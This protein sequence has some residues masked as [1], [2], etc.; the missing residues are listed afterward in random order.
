M[1]GGLF[2]K[3]PPEIPKR[4]GELLIEEGLITEA[5]LTKALEHQKKHGG[6][7]VDILIG[8]GSIDA[9]TFVK[10][11]SKRPGIPSIDLRNYEVPREL[12]ALIPKEL[13][14]KHEI[15]PIDKMGKVLT[16]G[17]AFPLDR[18]TI[19][20]LQSVTGFKIRPILC[21]GDDIRSAIKQYYGREERA[22]LAR[23][24]KIEVVE[25][26]AESA[27]RIGNI[28]SL[29]KEITV[30]P[31]LPRTV[32]QLRRIIDDPKSSISDVAH[33]LSLDPPASAKLLSITNSAAFSFSRQVRNVQ[34]AVALLGLRQTYETVLSAAAL[35]FFKRAPFFDHNLYWQDAMECANI[36]TIISRSAGLQTLDGV[37][38][39]GIM[40]DIGRMALAWIAPERF[41]KVDQTEGA[42]KMVESEREIFLVAHPEVG[43]MLTSNWGLP[44]QMT[45][46]IRFHHSYEMA[47][48][49]VETAAVI[50]LACG[51]LD[52][53]DLHVDIDEAF[54]QKHLD[55]LDCLKIDRKKFEG[56]L[57]KIAE[58]Q[59]K[60]QDD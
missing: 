8:Q 54:Y 47:P 23:D 15:F 34:E 17:M 2:V 57:K 14:T 18:A 10:F 30:L 31:P 19:E 46:A 38:A 50:A 44:E 26:R 59:A 43:Y 13:A 27:L 3:K 48:E 33:L 28:G 39:A 52:N 42:G 40:H 5:D 4:I 51:V 1:S 7:T 56:I 24:E 21:S 29:V 41:A 11:L 45:L 20:K 37:F 22:V 36:S 6:K 35:D 12:V 32:E 58:S 49:P 55:A 60:K 9:A 16:L 25:E 53:F